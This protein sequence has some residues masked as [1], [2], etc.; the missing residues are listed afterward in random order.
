MLNTG[1]I[2]YFKKV[3]RQTKRGSP[4]IGFKGGNGFGLM[5]GI[6]PP[7]G[8]EPDNSVLIALMAQTGYISFDDIIEFIGKEQCDIIIEKFKL[9]YTPKKKIESKLIVPSHLRIE[10]PNGPVL[11]APSSVTILKKEIPDE[12]A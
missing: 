3:T 2:I 9:K 10:G 12:Q 4:E 1:D 5:L 7:F 11:S 8:A 6:V